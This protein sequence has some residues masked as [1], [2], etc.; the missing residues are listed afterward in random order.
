MNIINADEALF[1]TVE[2]CFPEHLNEISVEISKAI[3]SGKQFVYIDAFG[4][5]DVSKSL[6]DNVS[7]NG[8]CVIDMIER[9]L[10]KKGYQVDL[11]TGTVTGCEQTDVPRSWMLIGW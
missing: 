11:F 7:S 5:L 3:S 1:K 10:L 6:N 8:N 9:Y 4:D 2:N